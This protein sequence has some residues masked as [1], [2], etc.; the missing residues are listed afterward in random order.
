M[1][2]YATAIEI[3]RLIIQTWCFPGM[4]HY[5]IQ[6]NHCKH[7]FGKLYWKGE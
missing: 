2:T 5:F 7:L 4:E 6:D 1:P 3:G